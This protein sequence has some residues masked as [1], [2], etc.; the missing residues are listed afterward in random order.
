[1]EVILSRHMLQALILA[2]KK[3][4]AIWTRKALNNLRKKAAAVPVICSYLQQKEAV[5][6]PTNINAQVLKTN[7]QTFLFIIHLE[8]FYQ[9]FNMKTFIPGM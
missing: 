1:M 8:N 4:K 9:F 5:S 6:W 3:K 2:A 7:F